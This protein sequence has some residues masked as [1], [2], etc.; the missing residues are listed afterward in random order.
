MTAE[1]TFSPRWNMQRSSS[2]PVRWTGFDPSGDGYDWM[3]EAIGAGWR[4]IASWGADGWDMG[5]WPYVIVG[6]RML[7]DNTY[8]SIVRVEG[9]L[10][11]RHHPDH[12]DLTEF[13]NKTAHAYWQR[14]GR[15]PDDLTSEA[16]K[17]WY[18]AG[19]IGV[20]NG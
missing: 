14:D 6:Y 16:A 15:G 13:L 18:S 11:A 3:D 7:P 12:A 8:I 19:R 20:R 9:D 1:A 2:Y 4:V 17:G 5:D 10:I